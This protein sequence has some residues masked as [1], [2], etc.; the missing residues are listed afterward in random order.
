M[1]KEYIQ[2]FLQAAETIAEQYFGIPV[3]RSTISLDETLQLE[4]KD[5]V[6][7]IAMRKDV[8]GL[9]VIGV[10]KDEGEK[11]KSQAMSIQGIG[12]N[13]DFAKSVSSEEYKKIKDSSLLEFANQVNG[14]VTNLYE[15]EKI[16]CDIT[17]PTYLSPDQLD[18]Y[19][20]ECVRF[21][22]KNKLANIVLKL[23][24]N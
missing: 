12:E 3:I 8:K 15:K 5:I 16:D 10:T 21:E 20:K 13:S 7:A 4:D 19:K 11:L 14:Y 9:V 24:I 6:I 2:P 18:K 17:T 1:R 23:Y 22:V